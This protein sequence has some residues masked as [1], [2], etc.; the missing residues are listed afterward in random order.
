[1]ALKAV[2]ADHQAMFTEGLQAILHNMK[3]PPIK[4]V[5]VANHPDELTRLTPFYFDIL[6]LDIGIFSNLGL[7][8]IQEIKKAKPNVKIVV[9]T[10]YSDPSMV[11][12][13]FLKG[14]DGYL[15][16]TGQII[17]LF[18]CIED[19]FQNKTFLGEGV[20]LSPEKKTVKKNT[21]PVS[22]YK[23]YED[24]FLLKQ[25]LSRRESEVLRHIVNAKSTKEIAE[26][27]Y[28][29][30]QT[31]SAHRKSIMRKLGANTTANLIKFALENQLV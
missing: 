4:I 5:G 1:M 6:I 27:L 20:R 16:K 14:V 28:I 31:V 15:L 22:A 19:V 30:N 7:D 2:I 17:E 8:T 11:R 24:R 26:E 25:K 10:T 9:L 13:S 12:D 18:E 3:S 29:S 21:D 23:V